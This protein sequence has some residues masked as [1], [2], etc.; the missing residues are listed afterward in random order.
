MKKLS[1]LVVALSILSP[2]FAN[3]ENKYR[4]FQDLENSSLSCYQIDSNFDSSNISNCLINS[5][6]LVKKRI[7]NELLK[8]ST[9][10]RN[11]VLNNRGFDI[12]V[13]KNSCKKWFSDKNLSMECELRSNVSYLQYLIMRFKNE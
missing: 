9:S 6:R 12:E 8:L 3:D 1:I 5:N 4:G 13:Q 7:N 10:D 11:F 2:A